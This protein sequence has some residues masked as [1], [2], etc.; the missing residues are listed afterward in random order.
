MNPK[1]I[2]QEIVKEKEVKS[3]VFVGCGASKADLYPAKYF[4]DQNAK[5]LRISHFTANEF[6]HATP[7]SL[8]ETRYYILQKALEIKAELIIKIHF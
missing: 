4:L 3:I 2:V 6:N 1:Q 7:A 5:Q 8:D